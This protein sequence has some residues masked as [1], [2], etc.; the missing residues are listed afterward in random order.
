MGS[1]I[2]TRILEIGLFIGILLHIIQGYI[3]A[4]QNQSR[5]KKGYAVSLG[6]RGSRWYTRSMGLLGTLI[7]LFLIMHIAHFWVPSRVTH[8]LAPV[9]LP[10]GTTVHNLYGKMVDVFTGNLL[11]VVL[12]VLGCISLA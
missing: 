10:N 9:T 11:V 7:L 6:N 12:Y 3:L 5:R 4:G 1:T 2:V 8:D